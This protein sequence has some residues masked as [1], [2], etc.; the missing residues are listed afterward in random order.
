MEIDHKIATYETLP[1]GGTSGTWTKAGASVWTHVNDYAKTSAQAGQFERQEYDSTFATVLNKVT[2]VH[3]HR[4]PENPAYT[5]TELATDKPRGHQRGP[6][7]TCTGAH[8]TGT[9][10]ILL[11]R[12][13]MTES[14]AQAGSGTA[15]QLDQTNAESHA[16][17]TRKLL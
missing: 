14:I 9:L 5:G 10:A 1:H 8:R 12:T 7:N 2:N 13:D 15:T 16:A 17:R 11:D 3:A 4:I 6:V